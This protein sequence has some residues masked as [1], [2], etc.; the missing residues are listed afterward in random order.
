MWNKASAARE[1][2]SRD[3]VSQQNLQEEAV[4]GNGVKAAG[5]VVLGFQKDHIYDLMHLYKLEA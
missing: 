5:T 1:S 3:W 4:R 2:G